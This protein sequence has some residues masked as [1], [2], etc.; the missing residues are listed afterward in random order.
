[1]ITDPNNE[2]RLKVR[3]ALR[4]QE[5]REHRIGKYVVDREVEDYFRKARE[6]EDD[7]RPA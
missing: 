7:P 1:M 5:E 3:E 4:A 6:K 2:R